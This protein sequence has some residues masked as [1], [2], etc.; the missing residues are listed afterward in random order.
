MHV[1]QLREEDSE[2]KGGKEVAG[3]EGK[4]GKR[5]RS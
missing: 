5:R 3:L 4:G 1:K 2:R